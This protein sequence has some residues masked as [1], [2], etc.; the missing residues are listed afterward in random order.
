[1]EGCWYQQQGIELFHF[2][3]VGFSKKECCI[4]CLL[5]A[6]FSSIKTQANDSNG[7]S[8][9]GSSSTAND[10]KSDAPNYRE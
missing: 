8:K 4:C 10:S 6:A 7:N 9:V 1:M 5:L 2:D 3:I